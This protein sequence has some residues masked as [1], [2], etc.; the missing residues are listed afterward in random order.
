M[1]FAG[2][3]VAQ[4]ATFVHRCLLDVMFLRN[5]AVSEV[6][7]GA[8]HGGVVAGEAARRLAKLGGTMPDLMVP[9]RRRYFGVEED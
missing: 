8:L 4:F 6:T 9:P 7:G 1:L 5:A 3:L 2:L